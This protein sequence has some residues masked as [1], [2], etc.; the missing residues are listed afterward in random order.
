[1]TIILMNICKKIVI[2]KEMCFRGMMVKIDGCFMNVFLTNDVYN[3]LI[4]F[5]MDSSFRWFIS[6]TVVV[7]MS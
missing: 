4:E 1:M 7:I 6:Q 5:T 2:F 3:K